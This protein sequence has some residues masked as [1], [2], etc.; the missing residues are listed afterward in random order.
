MKRQF[1]SG[2]ILTF[3]YREDKKKFYEWEHPN[4]ILVS[5]VE[6][7]QQKHIVWRLI[8]VA[9]FLVWF[10]GFIKNTDDKSS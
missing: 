1:K 9:E 8:R 4:S 3:F 7:F 10:E 2:S 6:S 5:S